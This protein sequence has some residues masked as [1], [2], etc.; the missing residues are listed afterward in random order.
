MNDIEILT[1]VQVMAGV[2]LEF[3]DDS[4]IG[5]IEFMMDRQKKGAREGELVLRFGYDM[6]GVTDKKHTYVSG[7][8]KV[9]CGKVVVWRRPK[10]EL[11]HI[12]CK[13]NAYVLRSFMALNPD[14]IWPAVRKAADRVAEELIDAD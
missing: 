7:T 12:G 13:R 11:K 9:E 3:N 2:L 5:D 6:H 14:L 10:R 1:A 4:R 8:V